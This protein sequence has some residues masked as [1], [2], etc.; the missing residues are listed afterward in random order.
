LKEAIVFSSDE[1]VRVRC[2]FPA[3]ANV[4]F[5]TMLRRKAVYTI[6]FGIFCL[7]AAAAR[8]MLSKKP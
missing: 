1:H 2:R 8:E 7:C 5:S 3:P 6:F 4:E